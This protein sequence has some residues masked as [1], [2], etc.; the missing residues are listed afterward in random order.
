VSADGVSVFAVTV[1]A[2]TDVET[3]AEVS[4]SD[5]AA[6]DDR[7]DFLVVEDCVETDVLGVGFVFGVTVCD[8]GLLPV[9]DPDGVAV[10][11]APVTVASSPAADV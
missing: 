3:A 7:R 6:A 5:T 1:L 4:G 11:S 2:V 8:P 10:G 9:S